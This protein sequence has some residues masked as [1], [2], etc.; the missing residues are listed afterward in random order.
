MSSLLFGVSASSL[1][2]APSAS[3]SHRR[4]Q[5]L[6]HMI[7]DDIA[8]RR[9]SPPRL[10]RPRLR[11][12]LGQQVTWSCVQELEAADG[13]CML[14]DAA[15]SACRSL[16]GQSGSDHVAEGH[17]ARSNE[18]IRSG[19]EADGESAARDM[20]DHDGVQEERCS[21][22]VTLAF[23]LCLREGQQPAET[24]TDTDGYIVSCSAFG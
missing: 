9:Q 21:Q 15:V 14:S 10:A 22:A 2:Q 24:A 16:G 6:W 20:Q 7:Q 4:R 13:A 11:Q 5:L 23:E 3:F 18:K 17:G 12:L 19:K 1:Q 8:L